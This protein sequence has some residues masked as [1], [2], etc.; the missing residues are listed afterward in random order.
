MNEPETRDA[1]RLDHFIALCQ[2]ASRRKAKDLV[3]AGK[4]TINGRTCFDSSYRVQEEDR[5]RYSGR[6]I[7]ATRRRAYIMLNKPPLFISSLRDEQSRNLAVD[8]V[9]PLTELRVYNVGRLDYLSSGLLLFTND[10]SFSQ[11]LMHPSQKIERTYEVTTQKPLPEEMLRRF[12]TG[13]WID[14]EFF[15]LKRYKRTGA[16]SVEI[17]LTEGRNREIRRVFMF[18][19]IGIRRLH[20]L[21]IGPLRLGSLRS[22]QARFLSESEVKSLKRLGEAPK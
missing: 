15:A 6:E 7:R 3:E 21:R 5:V 13:I 19:K 4:I 18:Y 16:R 12:Q 11:A 17:I 22:G 10:G 14:Q 9:R 1:P 8:L 20:R 2:V